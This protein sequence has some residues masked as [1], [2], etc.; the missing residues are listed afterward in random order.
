MDYEIEPEVIF[1]Y[2]IIIL[3]FIVI[4]FLIL[5]WSYLVKSPK[6]IRKPVSLS[7]TGYGMRCL[8]SQTS[9]V[10]TPE[11]EF[12][13]EILTPQF[14]AP[15]L[16]CEQ[17]ISQ[18]YN[19]PGQVWGICKKSIGTKCNSINEC[20]SNA[21][22]CFDVCSLTSAGGLNQRGPCVELTLDENENG[23][24]KI[25]NNNTGCNINTDCLENNSRCINNICLISQENGGRCNANYECLSNNCKNNYCQDPNILPGQEGSICNYKELTCNAPYS[26]NLDL[27]NSSRDVGFCVQES[28]VWPSAYCDISM[29]CIEPSIC[30]GG[31]CVLQRTET[32]YETNQCNITQTCTDG[33]VCT[34]N[35]CLANNYSKVP[36]P[37][38]NL[39]LVSWVPSN[40]LNKIGNWK[41]NLDIPLAPS[42]EATLTTLT[43]K[44]NLQ[45]NTQQNTDIIIYKTSQN[46]VCCAPGSTVFRNI[47]ITFP[48]PASVTNLLFTPNGGLLVSYIINSIPRMYLFEKYP[49]TLGTIQNSYIINIPNTSSENYTT[50]SGNIL[51]VFNQVD[52]DDRIDSNGNV[53]VSI[54]SDT[55]L[56]IGIISVSYLNGTGGSGIFNYV[57]QKISWCQLYS[58]SS[59]TFQIYEYMFKIANE[60]NRIYIN[61]ENGIYDQLFPPDDLDETGSAIVVNQNLYSPTS[62]EITE[63]TLIYL[64][65]YNSGVELRVYNNGLDLIFP[66]YFN[67]SSQLNLSKKIPE[68]DATTFVPSYYVITSVK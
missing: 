18:E 27:L 1:Y 62:T 23:I 63:I 35:I 28:N 4:I 9:Q 40:T 37:S 17:L 7:N 20:T 67:E 31:N 50:N 22:G 47:N 55:N 25:K 46:W 21:Y 5:Y 42:A 48:S 57:R 51:S 19:L 45:Q 53:K 29:S 26:C 11:E 43:I 15:G 36:F 58:Y 38:N 16:T 6:D 2:I 41:F 13:Y 64:V 61:R 60:N 32:K 65:K 30:W 10:L 54:V 8:I 24:C 56:Y 12:E 68:I 3:I 14:C 66:G 39:G 44:Q 49:Q 52:I 33:Y 59:K 34:N